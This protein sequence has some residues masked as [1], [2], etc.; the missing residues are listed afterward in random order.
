MGTTECIGS[1]NNYLTLIRIHF[2][3]NPDLPKLTL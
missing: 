1:L 2:E 3:I